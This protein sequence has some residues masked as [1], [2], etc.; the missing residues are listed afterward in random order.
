[1]P[2]ILNESEAKDFD[3]DQLASE[4]AKEEY[5][6]HQ[7]KGI[8]EDKANSQPYAVVNLMTSKFDKTRKHQ[9]HKFSSS[10]KKEPLKYCP[11][12]PD[13]YEVF[14]SNPGKF[15]VIEVR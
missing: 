10:R 12:I 7:K 6:R 1:M 14:K 2:V 11:K 8:L 13:V 9:N 5:L 4:I 3:L 15:S